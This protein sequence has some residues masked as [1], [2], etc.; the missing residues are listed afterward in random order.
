MLSQSKWRS[1][2]NRNQTAGAFSFWLSY[3]NTAF[4]GLD[5]MN[6]IDCSFFKVAVFNVY[7]QCLPFPET[8]VST[9]IFR[10]GRLEISMYF[11]NLYWLDVKEIKEKF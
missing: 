11:W 9:I 5:R 2:R 4:D 1:L 6:Y 8:A 10:D 7:S 3:N